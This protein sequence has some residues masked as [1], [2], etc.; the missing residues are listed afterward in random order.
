MT[1]AAGSVGAAAP[2]ARPAAMPLRSKAVRRRVDFGARL[3]S[4]AAALLGLVFCAWILVTVLLRGARSLT[5][6]FFTQLPPPPG[7][8][9][10]GLG[11]AMLGTLY[12]T[13]L[14][15]LIGVPTGIFTGLYLTEYGRHTWLGAAVRFVVNMMMGV[16]SI[17][18][19][20]FVYTLMVVPLGHF[21]GY[22]G[23]VALA[24][25][26]TPIVARTTEDMLKLVPNALRE[27]A[28]GLGAPR[29]R[30]IV[31]VLFPSAK[32]GLITGVMLAL[33]RVSGETAPLLF[34]ALNSPYWA[35][36]LS[37]PTANLTVT[38]FAFAMSPYSRWQTMAWGAALVITL[39]VLSI[40]VAARTILKGTRHE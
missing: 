14:A 1:P 24:L 2:A 30:M 29:W 37:M 13:A 17:I 6:A 20:L 27:A 26:I 39:A 28:L 40:T 3:I 10:G 19:G 25:L 5:P 11:N 36:T 8:E 22:A 38:L 35:D 12:M 16:P 33:A 31:W 15:T 32:A 34:T 23:G 21:S 9:G 4:V 7:V 18:M